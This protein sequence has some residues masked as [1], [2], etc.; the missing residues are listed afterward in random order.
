MEDAR[1]TIDR[2]KRREL[3]YKADEILHN[4]PPWLYLWQEFF[5]YAVSCRIVF[6]GRVDTMI[7][8]DQISVDPANKGGG[9]CH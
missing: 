4:D 9:R 7:L 2:A 6:D 1:Y 8:P 3:Y 5:L